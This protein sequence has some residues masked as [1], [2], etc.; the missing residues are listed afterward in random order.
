MLHDALPGVNF[1][2]KTTRQNRL[3]D[4]T[5]ELMVAQPVGELFHLTQC[6]QQS[7][8]LHC[9]VGV[10]GRGELRFSLLPRVQLQ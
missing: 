2:G 4:R 6:V 10:V 7:V 3:A 8:H 5:I 1:V 9:K